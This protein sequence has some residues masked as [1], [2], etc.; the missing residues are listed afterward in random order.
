MRLVWEVSRTIE[1]FEEYAGLSFR[2]RKAQDYTVRSEEP[3]N[4]KLDSNWAAG[5][6][7]LAGSDQAGQD[8]VSSGELE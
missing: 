4:P 8:S 5:N 2:L 6:L 1:E 7:L 3:P